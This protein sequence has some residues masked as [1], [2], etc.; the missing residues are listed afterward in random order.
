MGY[1]PSNECIPCCWPPA[2]PPLS[3]RCWPPIW[4]PSAPS[5]WSS[6]RVSLSRCSIYLPEHLAHF[7]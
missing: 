1:I 6:D 4:P 5:M 2:R 3:L 7:T